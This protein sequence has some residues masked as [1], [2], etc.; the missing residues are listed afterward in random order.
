[1]GARTS[2]LAS[3]LVEKAAQ[4]PGFQLVDVTSDSLRCFSL[5]T[6]A[7]KGKVNL[8]ET[9]QVSVFSRWVVLREGSVFCCGGRDLKET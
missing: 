3:P 1:M 2:P 5:V 7:W 6:N 4:H 8:Q 9:I